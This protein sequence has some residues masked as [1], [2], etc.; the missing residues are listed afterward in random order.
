MTTTIAPSCF[1]SAVYL[2]GKHGMHHSNKEQRCTPAG[3]A[4]RTHALM[5]ISDP[6]NARNSPSFDDLFQVV[7]PSIISPKFSQT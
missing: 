4:K 3:V 1:V 6:E 5:E 7:N 2:K